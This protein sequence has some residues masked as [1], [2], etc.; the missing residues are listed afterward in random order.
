VTSS[1]SWPFSRREARNATIVATSDV[2]VLTLTAD[3]MRV[4][5]DT[6]PL[7]A[8]RIDDVIAQRRHLL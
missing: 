2:R 4:V 3:Y 7:V 8:Q 5:R 1:A 6:I